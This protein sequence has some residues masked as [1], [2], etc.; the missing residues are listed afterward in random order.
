VAEE[1][2]QQARLIPTS[3]ISGPEEAERRATSAL[4]AVITA[5]REFGAAVI[6]PLGAPA[7]AIEAFI[8]V[9]FKLGDATVYPDGVIQTTRGGHAWTL[10]VEVKTGTMQLRKEQ[11]EAYLEV[12]RENNYAG[13]LTISNAIAPEPGVHPVA[14]DKRKLRKASL[15]HLSWAEVLTIA[16]QQRVFRG[17]SD[18]D[19]A[20]ILEELIRYLEHPKSGALDFAD[21]GPTWVPV[22][23]AVAAGTLR[24]T[25][26]GVD[27]VVTHWEQLLRFAALRLAREL[28]ADV[29]VLLTRKELSDPA[30]R[31]AAL[32]ESLCQE[33]SLYGQ[34]RIADAAAPL[35]V[36][37][38][39][40]GGRISVSI[41]VSAPKDGRATTRVNWLTR[42]LHDAPDGLRV[43]AFA[44]GS[45]TSTSKL[46]K[47]VREDP[48]ALIE[49]PQRELRLFRIAAT[50]PMGAKRN[51]GRGG[52]IDSV[53][54]SID[55]FYGAVVQQV[56][57][58]AAKAPQLP[59]GAQLAAEQAGIDVTPP[60]GD[61]AEREDSDHETAQELEID[62]E[63]DVEPFTAEPAG[64]E[65]VSWAQAE[66][67]LE[68]ER[69]HTDPGSTVDDSEDEH[70]AVVGAETAPVDDGSE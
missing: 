49:E 38:D 36:L 57:P 9:P 16:V 20:W 37:A 45:R 5:V 12:A 51:A 28:G 4:L 35:N 53:L 67:R 68:R 44:T 69:L 56:R 54:T 1:H 70:E 64:A 10:L 61:V 23:E 2:W 29:G 22:R 26:K 21:M 59:K 39:L 40:S 18:P 17:V 3:G 8:E 30:I 55:G 60:P 42:Q 65:V 7:G 11:I 32:V 14:I 6:R 34:L 19:Q 66:Q 25:D 62:I 46:L 43:E 63:N 31:H 27:E 48:S 15:W 52:F 58:W 50:T 33:H 47:E 24:S 13:V 41:D